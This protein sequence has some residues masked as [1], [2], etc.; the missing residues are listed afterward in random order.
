MQLQIF[1]KIVLPVPEVIFLPVI[2]TQHIHPA[3]YL[4]WKV[5]KEPGRSAVV[6]MVTSGTGWQAHGEHKT[7]TSS[8]DHTIHGPQTVEVFSGLRLSVLFQPQIPQG[9]LL[10]FCRTPQLQLLLPQQ[11]L[12]N[13]TPSPHKCPPPLF[14]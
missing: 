10:P 5:R 12:R 1:S 11:P 4:A 7:G 13:P 8:R 9:S 14:S 3:K 6:P 2:Q